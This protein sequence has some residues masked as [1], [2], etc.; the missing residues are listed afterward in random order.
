MKATRQQ[1]IK[2]V[3]AATDFSEPARVALSWAMAMSRIHGAVLHI[4]HAVSRTLP[5]VDRLEPFALLG[6]I[7]TGVEDR[8]LG[9]LKST[10]HSPDQPVECHLV[11]D[12][13]SEATLAVAERVGGGLIVLGT[14]GEGGFPQLHLGSTAE[15]VVQGATCPVLT[16][17]PESKRPAGKLSRILVAT[18][19]SSE[20]DAVMHAVER[21]FPQR[22]RSAEILLISVL[23][24]PLG[25]EEGVETKKLWHDYVRECRGLLQERLDRL[26]GS[27]QSQSF[28]GR[29]ILREG[30]PAVEIVRVAI[31]EEVHLIA[32]GSRGGFAAGRVFLGSVSKRVVQTAPI[33][34]L[35]VPSH[36][37]RT[38]RPSQSPPR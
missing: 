10:L 7:S 5:F 31:S 35:T 18:D 8:L 17:S 11:A 27:F 6:E 37:S 21:I 23:Q 25:L 2:A 38:T 32:L 19:F 20:A 15:R 12:R 30:I 29:V 13:P 14:R 33:P 36:L 4:V 26:L 28:S 3:V 9:R 16:V 22:E 34:V 24:I 1:D